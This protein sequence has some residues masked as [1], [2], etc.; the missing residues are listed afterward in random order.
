MNRIM[1]EDSLFGMKG[2]VLKSCIAVRHRELAGR[3][4]EKEQS[5][6]GKGKIDTCDQILKEKAHLSTKSY[7]NEDKGFPKVSNRKPTDLIAK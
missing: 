6:H 7:N 2:S 4:P 1:Q 3:S 5:T